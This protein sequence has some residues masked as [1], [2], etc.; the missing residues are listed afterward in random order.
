M[1]Q[2]IISID[3]GVKNLAICVLVNDSSC[4][5]NRNVQNGTLE[6]LFWKCYDVTEKHE[7]KIINEVGVKRKKR[8]KRISSQTELEK[9]GICQN[10]LKRTKK[11]CGKRGILNSRGRAYCG[12]HNPNKKHT[13]ED[14]QQ[15]CYSM[16]KT[17]PG[18]T[19]DLLESICAHF[20]VKDV[21]D[22]SNA[23]SIIKVMIEQQSLD[24]KRILLQSH[25]IYGHFVNLFDNEILVRF[26]PAYNKLL[27]YD[28]PNIVSNLKTPYARRKFF[29]KAYTAYYLDEFRTLHE[30]R[31]FFDSCKN[32]QDD[33]SDAFLQGMYILHGKAPGSK[34]TN[35]KS[36]RVVKRRKVK[37]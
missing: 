23:S 27:V 25:I 34:E 30:W 7:N 2:C 4:I 35:D 5:N 17:L 21:K 12:L 15:W 37:F 20:K 6:I 26:V 31:P 19:T 8:V 13:P 29:A 28:G 10:L 33:I 3:V 36:V 22:I 14:T 9:F 24:N 18:I 1:K 11:P 32:K 16:I